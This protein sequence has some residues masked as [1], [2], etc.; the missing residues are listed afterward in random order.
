MPANNNACG[1]S[2][3][4]NQIQGEHTLI[5][6]T[7]IKILRYFNNSWGYLKPFQHHTVPIIDQN[8]KTSQITFA[9]LFESTPMFI[10]YHQH[11]AR[12]SGIFKYLLITPNI[13]G[14][15]VE[16][17]FRG[18]DIGSCDI[19]KNRYRYRKKQKQYRIMQMIEKCN[20]VNL[21]VY[22]S[23]TV[24]KKCMKPVMV[25]LKDLLPTIYLSS[26][27]QLLISIAHAL[28]S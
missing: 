1:C 17:F 15:G 21:H 3:L 9:N 6:R 27:T 22:A 5:L 26:P 24:K 25:R 12:W 20:L 13:R 28:V 19:E 11:S 18:V 10:L 16:H 8:I 7:D 23:Q 14:G 2:M 4:C